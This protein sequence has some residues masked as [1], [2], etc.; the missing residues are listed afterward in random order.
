MTLNGHTFDALLASAQLCRDT[1]A[2]IRSSRPD[3][4][5]YISPSA[6]RGRVG[7]LISHINKGVLGKIEPEVLAEEWG[8]DERGPRLH[9]LSALCGRTVTSS[10]DLMLYELQGILE[11]AVASDG[12]KWVLQPL[13]A[14]VMKAMVVSDEFS[15][16][17]WALPRNSD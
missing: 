1:M 10:H 13:P 12:Q 7:A 15:T 5:T 3:A 9:I 17:V 16:L 8:D 11:W 14:K 2:D 6:D 4:E